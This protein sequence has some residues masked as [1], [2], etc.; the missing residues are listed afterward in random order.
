MIRILFGRTWLARPRITG[1][2]PKTAAC[3]LALG[4]LAVACS[5][6][7]PPSFTKL[8]TVSSS[9][10]VGGQ[11]GALPPVNLCACMETALA[12]SGTDEPC[13]G[14]HLGVIGPDQ[15]CEAAQHACLIHPGCSGVV[16]CV[17]VCKNDQAGDLMCLGACMYGD[18]DDEGHELYRSWVDC[19]CSR[20]A[21][22]CNSYG[23]AV[24][25][26]NAG[27]GGVGGAG[28][29]G[30]VGGAGGAG[31]VGGGGGAGGTGG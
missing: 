1:Y 9:S 7:E 21:D 25:E 24:C 20:C 22:E 3:C 13:L 11:G 4:V 8:E 5:E 19:T 17:G 10:G 14:C 31:G 2:W 23:D 29:A 12:E 27:G 26:P 15:P 18:P 30:G 28:G 16:E 6:D